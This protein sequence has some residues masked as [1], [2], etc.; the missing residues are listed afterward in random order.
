MSIYRYSHLVVCDENHLELALSSKPNHWK[1]TVMSQSHET[2]RAK[3]TDGLDR[4]KNHNS[5]KLLLCTWLTWVL[6]SR[7]LT[8]NLSFSYGHCLSLVV[9]CC[10]PNMVSQ[11]FLVEKRKS[12]WLFCIRCPFLNTPPIGVAAMEVTHLLLWLH[13]LT[14]NAKHK[15]LLESIPWDYWKEQLSWR[16][17]E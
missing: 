17:T 2:K 9:Y 7:S 6:S 5:M 10:N 15:G 1:D 13:L 3:C 8:W 4:S 16:M 14:D 11:S 12:D